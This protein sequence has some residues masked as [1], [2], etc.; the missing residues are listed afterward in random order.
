MSKSKLKK[1]PID[2]SNFKLMIEGNYLYVDKTE[3]I[4]NLITQGRLY[5]L[6]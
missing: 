5:F 1:L 3:Q 4:Y 2:V 6:F